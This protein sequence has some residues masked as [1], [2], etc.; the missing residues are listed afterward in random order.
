[1]QTFNE[2]AL[3]MAIMEL[4]ENQGYIYQNGGVDLQGADG[5]AAA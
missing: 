1:M 4:F 3:E 5:G 2:H